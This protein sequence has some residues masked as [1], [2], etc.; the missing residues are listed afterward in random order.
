LTGSSNKPGIWGTCTEFSGGTP[1]SE[2][3]IIYNPEIQ[4]VKIHLKPETF[5]P[6]NDGFEDNVEIDIEIPFD[7]A[8]INI[9]IF[10]R[11]GRSIRTLL[12]S[13]NIGQ[14][15]SVYWDGKNNNGNFVNTG[16]YII[17]IEVLSEKEKYLKSFKETV[18]V[19]R[20]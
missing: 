9:N 11:Y 6:D 15:Y 16:I 2:N 18:A 4:N 8:R 12:N 10:D 1:G 14:R 7:E 3:S 17:L 13:Y 20:K 19:Y 5:S